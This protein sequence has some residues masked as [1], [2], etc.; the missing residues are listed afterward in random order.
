MLTIGY[1]GST[2]KGTDREMAVLSKPYETKTLDAAL[3]SALG[4]PA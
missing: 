3:N 1:A 4:K 2:L